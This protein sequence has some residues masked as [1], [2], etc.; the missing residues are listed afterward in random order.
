MPAI[1]GLVLGPNPHPDV[2]KSL[3]VRSMEDV[4]GQG[5]PDLGLDMFGFDI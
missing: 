4:L 3:L 2:F 1:T 5:I